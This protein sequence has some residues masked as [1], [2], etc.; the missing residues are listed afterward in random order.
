ME[1]SN[2]EETKSNYD[3]KIELKMTVTDTGIGIPEQ[4]QSSLFKLFGKTSSNHNRNKTGC[5]LG[6]TICKKIIQKLDGD[7]ILDSKQGVGT[8]IS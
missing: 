1:E 4:D 6:L 2:L 5:G 8:K 3:K 7:I